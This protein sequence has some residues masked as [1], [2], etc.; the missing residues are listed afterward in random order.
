MT[1]L[2]DR[3]L[4]ALDDL[5]SNPTIGKYFKIL[6]SCGDQANK[7]CECH[8]RIATVKILKSIVQHPVGI[9]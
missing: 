6:Y 2:A 9:K 7:C 5:D 3:S 1:R 8:L 4:V